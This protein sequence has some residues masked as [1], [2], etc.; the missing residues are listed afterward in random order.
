MS[1][2]AAVARLVVRSRK[3]R[4]GMMGSRAT[5][6]LDV[7]RRREHGEAE[8]DERVAGGRTPCELVAG[9]GDPDQQQ[10]DAAH[11]QGRAEVVDV[12]LTA[13]DGQVQRL[14][15]QD[16]GAATATGRPTKKHQRQPRPVSTRTNNTS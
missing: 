5:L 2:E 9:E 7:D 14:L 10:A 4:I 16:E 15:E 11:D 6:D 13:Y 3:S 1:T 12:H 8:H